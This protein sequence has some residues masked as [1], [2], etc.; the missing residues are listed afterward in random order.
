MFLLRYLDIC[1]TDSRNIGYFQ[2]NGRIP[3][4][5]IAE[6]PSRHV[7]KR[8]CPR[9][10]H[11]LMEPSHMKAQGVDDWL[12]HWLKLQV[13]KKRPLTLKKPS[14]AQ[15]EGSIPPIGRAKAKAT[16][17]GK[18][19]AR[20]TPEVSSSEEGDGEDSDNDTDDRNTDPGNDGEDTDTPSSQGNPHS[21]PVDNEIDIVD[22]ISG[23]PPPPSGAALSKESRRAFLNS[24]SDDKNYRQLIR[25]LDGAKVYTRLSCR[26]VRLADNCHEVRTSHWNTCTELG[27]LDVKEELSS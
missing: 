19:K 10:D 25:L 6:N 4:G 21:D 15:D 13:Q 26:I 14:D 5:D 1:E 7:N 18:E 20:D 11:K 22:R 8:S 16:G 3:W 9:S 24:L 27:N 12:R 17:K 23:L 2:F